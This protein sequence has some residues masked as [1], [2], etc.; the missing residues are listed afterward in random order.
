VKYCLHIETATED[1]SVALS[2]D[3]SLLR[4]LISE[5]KLSHAASL[6]PLIDQLFEKE[7]LRVDDLSAVAVSMGPGSYTG[8]R[9]GLSA[10]K[11]IA[12]AANIPLIGVSTLKSAAA[13]AKKAFDIVA[14]DIIMP[15]ID[16]R[17]MEVYAML[18]DF[19]MNVIKEAEA[20]IMEENSLNS[21]EADRII[22]S[23]NGAEKL[24]TLYGNDSRCVFID[25][26]VHLASNGIQE[27]FEKFGKEAFENTAYCEPFY[28]KEFIP[29][30]PKVK[31]LR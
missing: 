13:G 8:L 25:D 29:G 3:G 18:F 21:I 9:I 7:N 2:V 11:G 28:L 5:E 6:I 17:R 4:E 16:A 23:G 20:W 22:F 24:K 1:C 31:G 27:S 19:E 15:V 12:Y 26:R 10:A 30:K 14:N